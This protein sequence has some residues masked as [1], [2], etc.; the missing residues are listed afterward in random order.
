[1]QRPPAFGAI[2][3]PHRTVALMDFSYVMS[4]T[5]NELDSGRQ[6]ADDARSSLDR[7]ANELAQD[8]DG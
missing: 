6:L 4:S 1:M 8:G 2:L 7:L 3:E 5:T